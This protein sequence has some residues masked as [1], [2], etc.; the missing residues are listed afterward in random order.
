M[1]RIKVVAAGAAVI[2]AFLAGG[3]LL[4]RGGSSSAAQVTRVEGTGGTRLF[5]AV[6]QTIRNYAVDSLDETAVYRLATSGMLAELGDPYAALVSDAD[7]LRGEVSGPDPVQ[8]IYLDT[9]G[10]YVTVVSVLPD[11]PAALA[12]LRAGD[13]FLRIGDST[14][15]VQ[16]PE[17]IRRLVAGPSGTTVRLRVGRDG[18]APL[19]LSLVRSAAIEEPAPSVAAVGDDLVQLTAFRIDARAATL[20]RRTLD[21]A[22]THGGRGLIVDLRGAAAGTLAGALAFAEVLLGNGETIAVARTRATG[23]S[24]VH[25][26]GSAAVHPDFGVVVLVDRGTAGPA[27]VVAGSL[28]DHDRAVILGE[29]T[30]GRGGRLSYF[31]VGGSQALRLTTE[32]WVTPGGRVIQRSL[33]GAAPEDPTD[34]LP[35]RPEFR[36]DG[37]RIVLG[38]GGIVPDR[39]MPL[40]AEPGRSSDPALA[41][42]RALLIKAPNRRALLAA[43]G[44]N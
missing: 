38:G 22:A 21:S 41:E 14:L 10:G 44:G 9:D 20:L 40:E 7:T 39:E 13:V 4:R 43:V 2:V 24:L 27:E 1:S 8:G 16:A 25:R 33:A 12:G 6:I 17:E 19:W 18:S 29:T 15:S 11:S 30:F 28:Q 31:R 34:T 42:A 23:D 36:T 32:V 3:W 5:D 37:G 26:S 35:P